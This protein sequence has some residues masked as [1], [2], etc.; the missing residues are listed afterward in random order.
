MCHGSD[1][2]VKMIVAKLFS[3]EYAKYGDFFVLEMESNE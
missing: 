3:K 2:M 1:K